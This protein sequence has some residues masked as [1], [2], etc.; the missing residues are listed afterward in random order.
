MRLLSPASSAEA[1]AG[2]VIP[3]EELSLRD[4]DMLGVPPFGSPLAGHLCPALL[5]EAVPAPPG[6]LLL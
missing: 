6:F 4:V 1:D 3:C 5:N 2:R